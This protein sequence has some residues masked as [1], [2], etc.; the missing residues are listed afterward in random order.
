MEWADVGGVE[1]IKKEVV[2]SLISS[3]LLSNKNGCDAFKRTGLLL[4]G[5]PGTGKTLLARAV[6]SQSKRAFVPVNGPDLL[7]MYVGQSEA[8]VRSGW[9]ISIYVPEYVMNTVIEFS[10][11]NI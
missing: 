5:P 3:R 6:A 4:Y 9:L 11:K 7:N 10:H 8:N 2:S 1:L